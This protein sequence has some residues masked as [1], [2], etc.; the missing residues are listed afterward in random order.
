MDLCPARYLSS[1]LFLI[2]N[3]WNAGQPIGLLTYWFADQLTDILTLWPILHRP[4]NCGVT[5]LAHKSSFWARSASE[6]AKARTGS[7]HTRPENHANDFEKV[8][9][10]TYWPTDRRTFWQS[11]WL[12]YWLDH[13]L[14]D[15]PTKNWLTGWPTDVLTLSPSLFWESYLVLLICQKWRNLLLTWQPEKYGGIKRVRIE[16]SLIWIP[17][18]VLYNKSVNILFTQS[19]L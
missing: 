14:T 2:R 17:D 15:W 1:S 8:Y 4:T 6:R 7:Y 9:G 5:R 18:I 13:W 10:V 3:G 11:D 19:L 16:P 12:T